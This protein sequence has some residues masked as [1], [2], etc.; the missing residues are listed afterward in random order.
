M[1]WVARRFLI[2]G[3]VQRVAYRYFTLRAAAR[4][5]ILGLVRN[6][7]DGRVEVVAEGEHDAM[8]QF[9]MELATGPLMARVTS[10][11]EIDVPVTNSFRDFRIDYFE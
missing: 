9:K 2:A 11:D 5:E 8:E 10:I 4:H 6:L 3:R 1:N 7:P